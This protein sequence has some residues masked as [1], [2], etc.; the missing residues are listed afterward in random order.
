MLE[1]QTVANVIKETETTVLTFTNTSTV[2]SLLSINIEGDARSEWNIY[3]NLTKVSRARTSVSKSSKPI[4]FYSHSLAINDIIDVKVIHYED[5]LA[6][7][8]ATLNYE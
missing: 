1:H 5:S 7:F 8:S 3:K 2:K 6:N 4:K